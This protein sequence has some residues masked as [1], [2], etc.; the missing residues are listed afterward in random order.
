[1]AYRG[2]TRYHSSNYGAV[3]RTANPPKKVLAKKWGI[4]PDSCPALRSLIFERT[5]RCNR[6]REDVTL[7]S[8][9]P[10]RLRF[11]LGEVYA[12]DQTLTGAL[13]AG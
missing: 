7:R 8:L 4:G 13:L 2:V 1:M 11:D 12:V 9:R 5:K 10:L 3:I 6:R